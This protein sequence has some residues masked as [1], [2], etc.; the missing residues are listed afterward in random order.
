MNFLGWRTNT[1]R[2]SHLGRPVAP[3]FQRLERRSLLTC[4]P[5]IAA[6]AGTVLQ[7]P[8]ATF[9]AGDVQGTLSEFQATIYWTGA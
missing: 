1:T 8:V 9:A 3:W 5:A 4:K 7:R 6:D 2:R